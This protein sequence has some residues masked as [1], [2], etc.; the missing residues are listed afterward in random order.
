MATKKKAKVM[1]K[2]E[3]TE[4]LTLTL[5]Q[6][7]KAVKKSKKS[8]DKK[9]VEKALKVTKKVIKK[10]EEQVEEK[11]PAEAEKAEKP[12]EEK[13]HVEAK[14][15]P[16]AKKAPAIKKATAKKAEKK[17][18]KEENPMDKFFPKTIEVE[19]T[20]FSRVQISS[21]E[22]FKTFVEA[23][24]GEGSTH[25]VIAC[26][27]PKKYKKDYDANNQGEKLFPKDG[28]EHD[29][30]LLE[31]LMLQQ[32]RETAITVSILTEAVILFREDYFELTDFGYFLEN[33][34]PFMIYTYTDSEE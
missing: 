13:N 3:L 18:E 22:E 26:N 6:E 11:K 16:V 23:C 14:K 32:T 9:P 31:V 21:W 15:A 34:M 25:V 5:E 17:A 24:Q 4:K 10:A 8:S 2:E 7:E 33:G 29:L 30:D 28:F 19:G 20:K 27:W 1:S 12:V